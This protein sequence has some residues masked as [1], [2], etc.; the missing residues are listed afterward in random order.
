MRL[1]TCVNCGEHYILGATKCPH[2][3]VDIAIKVRSVNR[4]SMALSMSVGLTACLVLTPE[5]KYGTPYIEEGFVADGF[6][7]FEDC[8]DDDSNTHLGAENDSTEEC[9]TDVDGDGFGDDNP[10]YAV[11]GTDCDNSDP[12]IHPNAEEIPDDGVDSNCDGEDN[13]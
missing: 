1:R 6:M 13:S 10:E 3:P 4:F 12:D 8:N 2:C 11:S 5:P 7:S 9:M